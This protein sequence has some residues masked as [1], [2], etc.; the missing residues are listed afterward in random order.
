MQNDPDYLF[1]TIIYDSSNE[2]MEK[3]YEVFEE[4]M[5]DYHYYLR[6]IAYDCADDEETCPENVKR[7]LP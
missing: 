6:L 4:V 7:Q 5:E 2:N 1:A 3:L